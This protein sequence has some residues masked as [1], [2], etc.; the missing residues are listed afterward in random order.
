MSCLSSLRMILEISDEYLC[1]PMLEVEGGLP[2]A[3]LGGE[4]HLLA[5]ARDAEGLQVFEGYLNDA[6]SGCGVV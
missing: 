5:V 1:V 4:L 3:R 6:R 2:L